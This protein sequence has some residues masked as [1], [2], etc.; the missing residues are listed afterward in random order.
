MLMGVSFDLDYKNI[1]LI[2]E[3]TDYTLHYFLHQMVSLLLLNFAPQI[4]PN[5]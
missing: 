2:L 4:K 1:T 3:P 5:S